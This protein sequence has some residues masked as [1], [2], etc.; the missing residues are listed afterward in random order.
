MRDD[1][2]NQLIEENGDNMDFDRNQADDIAGDG[3]D[4]RPSSSRVK[5]VLIWNPRRREFE[6]S[7]DDKRELREAH[8]KDPDLWR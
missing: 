1:T 6:M 7:E 3:L 5:K 4:I 2:S 8:I